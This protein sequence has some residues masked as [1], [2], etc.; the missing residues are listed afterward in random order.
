MYVINNDTIVCIDGNLLKYNTY[1]DTY[2]KLD[3]LESI[4]FIMD[5]NPIIEVSDTDKWSNDN[6]AIFR[7]ENGNIVKEN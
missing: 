3:I 7:V 2:K 4:I 1:S 6:G 5:K